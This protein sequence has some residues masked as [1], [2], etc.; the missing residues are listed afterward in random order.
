M[1]FKTTFKVQLHAMTY[2]AVLQF[3]E[4]MLILY[5]YFDLFEQVY[6]L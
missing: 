6:A 2:A 3:Y 4:L 5:F 1:Q